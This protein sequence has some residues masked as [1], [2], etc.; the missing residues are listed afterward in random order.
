[1][2]EIAARMLIY[3]PFNEDATDIC[4][5]KMHTY[6]GREAFDILSSCDNKS[7]GVIIPIRF[8]IET[9]ISQVGERDNHKEGISPEAVGLSQE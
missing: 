9:V 2:A 8:S 4:P 6:F 1:M 3:I 7:G 5:E